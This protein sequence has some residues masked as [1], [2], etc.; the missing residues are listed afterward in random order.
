MKVFTQ[1][2]GAYGGTRHI[3]FNDINEISVQGII[4]K[5]IDIFFTPNH[6]IEKIWRQIKL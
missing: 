3:V 5:S 1:I 6:M 4:N 2:K